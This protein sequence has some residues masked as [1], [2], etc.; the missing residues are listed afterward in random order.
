MNHA[1][2]WAAMILMVAAAVAPG[3]AQLPTVGTSAELV[4]LLAKE[5]GSTT[6]QAEG[7]AGSLPQFPTTSV[8]MR[9]RSELRP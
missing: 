4:S 8:V 7:A 3:A 5:L 2:C 6:T 9:W 1:I